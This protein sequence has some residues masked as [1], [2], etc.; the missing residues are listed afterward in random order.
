MKTYISIPVVE[1]LWTTNASAILGSA[2]G[3]NDGE[4]VGIAVGAVDGCK[5]SF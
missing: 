3:S 1:S 5:L 4:N 2:E